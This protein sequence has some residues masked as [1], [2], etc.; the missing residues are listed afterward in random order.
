MIKVRH[1]DLSTHTCIYIVY[2]HTHTYK[3]TLYDVSN[4]KRKCVCYMKLCFMG[5]LKF[6][7]YYFLLS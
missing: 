3:H 1:K 6:K 7:H 4:T 2:T 5:E